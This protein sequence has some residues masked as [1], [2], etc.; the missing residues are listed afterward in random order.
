[1]K[2]LT[3]TL[4]GGIYSPDPE[5]SLSY[6]SQLYS[7]N[8][9][10]LYAIIDGTVS[11]LSCSVSPKSRA[12]LISPEVFYPRWLLLTAGQAWPSRTSVWRL[13]SSRQVSLAGCPLSW[14][15]FC[16]ELCLSKLCHRGERHAAGVSGENQSLCPVPRC[17]PSWLQSCMGHAGSSQASRVLGSDL[18]ESLFGPC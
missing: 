16:P 13:A 18:G 8:V 11:P 10:F 12:L 14:L 15:F 17:R 7:W 5:S 1:M 6:I 3:H 4:L 2:P 9:Y